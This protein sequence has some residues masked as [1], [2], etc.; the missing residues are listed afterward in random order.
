[1]GRNDRGLVWSSEAG[2]VCPDC[3]APSDNCRCQKDD[4]ASPRGDGIVRVFRETKGRR[5]K[6]VTVVRGV[7]LGAAE[8]DDLARDLKRLCGTGG[9]VKDGAIEI[10]GDQRDRVVVALGERGY[11]VKKAG[12]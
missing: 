12:G 5:G 2:A 4:G 9:T 6:A 10:Q 7:P 3:G 1:M 8:L 11:R